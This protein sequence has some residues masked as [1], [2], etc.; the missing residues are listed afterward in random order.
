L[1]TGTDQRLLQTVTDSKPGVARIT[2][3][4]RLAR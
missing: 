4:E 3:Y 2:E 1:R